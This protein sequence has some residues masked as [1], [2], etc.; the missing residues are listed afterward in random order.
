MSNPLAKA[1][2]RKLSKSQLN[3]LAT[4]TDPAVILSVLKKN[5][6]TMAKCIENL[7]EIANNCD[8]DSTKLA[9]NKYLC[10]LVVDCMERSGMMVIAT[11]KTFGDEGE[12]IS[13]T[14]HV[15]SSVLQGPPSE[16]TT[17]E[18]LTGD[19]YPPEEETEN[20]TKT[21]EK[22]KRKTK[23]GSRKT[24]VLQSR[25]PSAAEDGGQPESDSGGEGEGD[26]DGGDRPG[27]TET[28]LSDALHSSKPPSVHQDSFRGLA[29]PATRAPLGPADG[30]STGAT[31]L[32]GSSED[33]AGEVE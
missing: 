25:G 13:F 23:T 17:I 8:K 6:W 3:Q 14:G 21:T 28:G 26:G 7:V 4:Y 24:G 19:D 5:D 22:R 10:Q 1:K 20:D 2:P 27:F 11:K 9:A 15:V 18:Q 31:F 12:E 33:G 29:I 16:Q 30:A 32:E